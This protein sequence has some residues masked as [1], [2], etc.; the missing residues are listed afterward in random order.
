MLASSCS[1]CSHTD[2]EDTQF[3]TEMCHYPFTVQYYRLTG[4]E[5]SKTTTVNMRDSEVTLEIVLMRR[6]QSCHQGQDQAQNSGQCSL[7]SFFP[8]CSLE[9]VCTTKWRSLLKSQFT[10]IPT[11]WGSPQ[12][13]IFIVPVLCSLL[14]LRSWKPEKHISHR[15]TV[16]SKYERFPACQ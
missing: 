10:P 9:G 5:G 12:F 7:L 1:L 13:Q 16:L 15:L 14:N 6:L 2:P 8:T 3:S 11:A 4:G